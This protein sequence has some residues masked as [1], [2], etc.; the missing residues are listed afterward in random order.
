MTE[1]RASPRRFLLHVVIMSYLKK[2]NNKIKEIKTFDLNFGNNKHFF[3]LVPCWFFL[4]SLKKKG[5]LSVFSMPSASSVARSLDL[6]GDS[7]WGSHTFHA[8]QTQLKSHHSVIAPCFF[9]LPENTFSFIHLAYGKLIRFLN[10]KVS[11][12]L[13]LLSLTLFSSYVSLFQRHYMPLRFPLHWVLEL[14]RHVA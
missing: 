1:A 8:L 13:I 4:R 9:S 2:N 14:R 12:S 7:G 11:F 3:L 5:I 10:N 6:S